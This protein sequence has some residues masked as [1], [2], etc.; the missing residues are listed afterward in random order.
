M[1]VGH[2]DVVQGVLHGTMLNGDEFVNAFV[3]SITK[4][5]LGDWSDSEIGTFVT[6]AIEKIFAELLA[7]LKSTVSFDTVDVYKREAT[8]WDYLTTAVPSITPTGSFEVLPGGVAMLMTAYTDLNRV[9]GR[10][11]IYGC[12]EADSSNGTLNATGLAALADAALEYI[13]NY[14][15][16]TMGP[17][18]F[19][20]PGVWSTK[21][22]AYQTFN[23]V[24]V[25][26]DVLSYQRRR[27]KGVGI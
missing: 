8:G 19:L 5:S 20:V 24:S 6:D 23:G 25:V 1:P 18:D 26:K 3:W 21:T 17:L 13:S 10:K 27:K 14:N 22:S 15:G 4:V 16:G 12:T 2:G 9:F 11:F 7:I